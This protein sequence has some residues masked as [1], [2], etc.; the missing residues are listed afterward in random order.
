M[1]N[2]KIRINRKNPNDFTDLRN[3]RLL[4]MH[5]PINGNIPCLILNHDGKYLFTIGHDGNVFVYEW[6]GP[7]V[8]VNKSKT[9]LMP[10]KVIPAEDI[11]NRE[12]P[13]LEQE[14]IY[15][16]IKRQEE[17]AAA[18]NRKVLSDIEMLQKKFDELLLS[19][20]AMHDDLR[21]PQHELLLDQRITNQIKD[22]LQ[23]ELDDVRDDLAFDLEVVQVGKQKLY[24]Y[25]FKRLDHIPIKISG[26]G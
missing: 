7:Q 4:N 15:A 5:D 20:E 9:V 6:F 16:E 3:Y 12:H 25:F 22:E 1:I 19:N 23:A 13:S 10:K 21:I 24:E 2:G 18:H 8:G 14:K 17:A 11:N 26:I